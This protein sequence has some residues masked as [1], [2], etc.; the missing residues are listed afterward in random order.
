[1]ARRG[2]GEGS[3]YQRKSDGKWV[4][5]I[6][7]ENRKRKVFYGNTRKE[8]QEKMKVALREQQQG[9]LVT[10]RQQ[11]LKQYL[12]DW[13][14]NTHKQNVR[15][16]THERYEE[17]V[18][19]HIIPTIGDMPLQKLTPQRLQKLYS[20]KQKEGY[21]PVTVI[22]IHN[23]LHK[24]LDTAVRWELLSQNVCDKVSPP[25]RVRPEMKS[26]TPEQAQQLLEAAR[27]HPQEAL[28]ILAISTGMRR[29]ELLGL[30]WQ[31]INFAE[32]TLQV[33]RILS[34]VPTKQV[35]ELGKSYIEAEPKTKQSRRSIALADL[36]I[37]ALKRHRERQLEMREKAGAA[38][39]EH[40]YVFCTPLGK[41]LHPGHD[42][43]EALKTLLKKAGLPD[44]R[45]HDLRHSA[46]TMLLSMGTHP[47]VVQEL[48]G[49]T[50]ISMTMDIYSH[51]LPTMQHEAMGKMNDV[52]R[53]R[54]EGKDGQE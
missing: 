45:F 3:I 17:I 13:L 4:G 54:G 46:A 23:L 1:M 7:L 47:K 40:D 33:R 28:F 10:A 9:T 21:A 48:L 18:R 14:E 53:K 52:L 26:L 42:A 30:K 35:E 12:E 5:S 44:I 36:A 32:K 43:L 25:R 50:Q 24:A 49:H 27:G 31:D 20:D 16:R 6:M 37:D 29:G 22:A 39:E 19:L 34:R 2:N 51:V 38:W 8:V 15:P 41:H 11:S